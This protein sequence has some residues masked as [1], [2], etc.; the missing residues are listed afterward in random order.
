MRWCVCRPY[1][2]AHTALGYAATIDT[3]QG[4]TADTCHRRQRPT[5][6]PAPL[7]RADPR[8]AGNHLYFS[9]AEA[10]P[11][12]ILTPKAIHP[13]TAVDILT[14]ILRRDSAPQS[15]QSVLRESV[16]PAIRLGPASAMYL[17]A[18]GAAAEDCAVPKRSRVSTAPQLKSPVI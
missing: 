8:P 4:V 16:D 17:D 11:H 9:T 14:A 6:P 15:A 1:V 5:Q 18:L 12:R 13:P 2:A 3:R 7:R 10:D